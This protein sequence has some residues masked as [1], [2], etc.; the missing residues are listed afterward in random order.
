VTCHGGTREGEAADRPSLEVADIFRAHGEA[1]RRTHALTPEQLKV[2]GDIEACRTAI[3]GGHM[4]TCNH[5]GHEVPSYN[6]C[7]NRHCPK[8]QGHNQAKWLELR[9]ARTLP[10]HYF[11]TVFTL[12]EE[13]RSVARCNRKIIF[14]MLFKSAAETLL[15]LGGDKK[16]LGGLLGITAVLHTWTRKLDFH[17]HVHCIVTGG[18]LD[19]K[20]D[21]WIATDRDF[22]FP[23]QV[24][25][26]LFRGKFLAALDTANRKGILEFEGAAAI[27]KDKGRFAALKDSLYG[28]EW[29]V[30]AKRPFGGPMQVFKYLGRYTH[31]VAISNYRLLSM[32]DAGVTFKTRGERTVTLPPEEFIRR[33]LMHVLP[34]GFVKIRHYGLKSST[35][36]KTKLEQA[37]KIIEADLPDDDVPMTDDCKKEDFCLEQ[38]LASIEADRSL[39][40]RCKVGK[41]IRARIPK[42]A[43]FQIS[44][45]PKD[46]S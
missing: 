32:N 20:S 9:Q 38:T 25:S 39:C 41:M 11:H 33:F 23:V 28:K 26:R 37:R 7:L 19:E 30:Y 8:C 45:E 36:A 4:D 29:V 12:P 18:G 44:P 2:M 17:P 16:H 10:T 24:L 3:L 31:R 46:T 14:D 35:N 6:S 42:A 40:P 15:E 43:S 1:Y 21:K 27:L 34:K 22:L 13:L 5:C